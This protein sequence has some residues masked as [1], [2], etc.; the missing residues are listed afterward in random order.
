MSAA[1]EQ[2][3]ARLR[4]QGRVHPVDLVR[5]HVV[6][7]D[8]AAYFVVTDREGIEFCTCPASGECSHII[9]ARDEVPQLRAVGA[10]S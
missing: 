3:A 9:A 1:I 8:H 4:A 10:S 5:A 2:K 7:G 6:Q